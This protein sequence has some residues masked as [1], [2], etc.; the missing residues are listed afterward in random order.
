VTGDKQAKRQLIALSVYIHF[1]CIQTLSNGTRKGRWGGGES[2][3]RVFA[4]ALP[5]KQKKSTYFLL[6]LSFVPPF[7]PRVL[8]LAFLGGSGQWANGSSKTQK[9]KNYTYIVH[10]ASGPI[11]NM[12]RAPPPPSSLDCFSSM[13]IFFIFWAFRNKRRGGG[14][15]GSQI[16]KNTS[17]SKKK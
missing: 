11:K 7:L 14:G 16:P 15:G 10:R 12:R 13:C 4:A 1:I 5:K 3:G 6:A 9:K 17:A 2:K 8:F